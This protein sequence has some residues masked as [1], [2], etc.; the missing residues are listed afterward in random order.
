VEARGGGAG[1]EAHGRGVSMEAHGRGGMEALTAAS[2]P[3][4]APPP[5]CPMEEHGDGSTTMSGWVGSDEL[6]EGGGG[7]DGSTTT[8]VVQ[9]QPNDGWIGSGPCGPKSGLMSF[10][11]VEN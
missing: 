8:M 9:W 3:S 5:P 1:M 7:S 10:F 11:I 4:C 6:G 2:W